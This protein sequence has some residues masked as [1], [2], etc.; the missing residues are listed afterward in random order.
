MNTNK[1]YGYIASDNP[2][3]AQKILS[4]FGYVTQS[5]NLADS[6]RQLVA[7]EGEDALQVIM[8]YHPDKDIILELFGSDTPCQECADKAVYEKYSNASGKSGASYNESSPAKAIE[9]NFSV[10]FLA[11]ITI[12]AIAIIKK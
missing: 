11:G 5:K 4:Q 7:K 3:V 2:Q 1:V 12:L 9:N 10:L 8:A 6:L